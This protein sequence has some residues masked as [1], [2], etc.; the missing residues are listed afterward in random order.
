MLLSRQKRCCK[1]ATMC[2]Q[3]QASRQQYV[4]IQL[5]PRVQ[6]QLA[7]KRQQHE[8]INSLH[9]CLPAVRAS[10][11]T[12]D[13]YWTD[14]ACQYAHPQLAS[15]CR[16][17]HSSTKPSYANKLISQKVQSHSYPH[18]IQPQLLGTKTPRSCTH[19]LA[20][21][22]K[23]DIRCPSE[24]EYMAGLSSDAVA[25]LDNVSRPSAHACRCQG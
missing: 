1:C 7:P 25:L 2:K 24:L 10:T 11:T 16:A 8:L 20:C 18:P 23:L 6:L 4:H 21:P 15:S 5:M 3:R 17:L 9:L 22:H 12:Q 13:L 19:R 14:G